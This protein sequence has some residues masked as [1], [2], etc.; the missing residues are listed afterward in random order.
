M[1]TDEVAERLSGRLECEVFAGTSLQELGFATVE[2]KHR[3]LR[4]VDVPFGIAASKQ[5]WR[6]T[7]GQETYF[8]T[9]EFE[10]LSKG[11]GATSALSAT[12]P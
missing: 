9:V 12:D 2:I 11:T 8:A 3:Q 6:V 4:H 10:L 1:V 7:L 5:E